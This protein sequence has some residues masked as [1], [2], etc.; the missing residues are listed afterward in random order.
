MVQV[1]LAEVVFGQVG[2]VGELDVRDVRG[3]EEADVHLRSVTLNISFFIFNF[4]SIFS[5]DSLIFATR[6][7][8]GS[9]RC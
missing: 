5:V 1:V 9:C 6:F 4:R 8:G 2:D 3:A 7:G